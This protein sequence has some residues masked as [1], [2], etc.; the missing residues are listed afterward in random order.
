[1]EQAAASL[2]KFLSNTSNNNLKHT[3]L[4]LLSQA[5]KNHPKLLEDYQLIIFKCLEFKE[6]ILKQETLDLLY[7]MTTNENS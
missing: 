2:S 5:N 6:K 1:M 3:G 7:R 4:R